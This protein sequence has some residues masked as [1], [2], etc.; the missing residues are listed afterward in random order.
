M[1]LDAVDVRDEGWSWRQV[2]I[3]VG[4]NIMLVYLSRNVRKIFPVLLTLVLL[5]CVALAIRSL[6]I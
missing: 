5:L 6:A 4:L 2:D 1:L 3:V